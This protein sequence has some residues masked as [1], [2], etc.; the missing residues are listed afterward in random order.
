MQKLVNQCAILVGLLLLGIGASCQK[1]PQGDG[2]PK[3]LLQ[4]YISKS[5]SVQGPEDRRELITFLTGEAKSRLSAWSDDQ[6]KQAFIE[7]K[8]QFVKLVI[9]DTKEVSPAEINLT[10]ELTFLDQARGQDAKVTNKKMAQMKN[11][12]GRWLISEVRNLKE[13]VEYRNEMSLP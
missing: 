5:F 9:Q 11:D 12:Q 2:S 8:R 13:M 3:E 4:G 6:F 1:K 7:N 10:Y